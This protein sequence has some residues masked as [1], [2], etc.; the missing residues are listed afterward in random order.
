MFSERSFSNNQ[1]K[2]EKMMK[3]TGEFRKALET[4]NLNEAENFLNEVAS[5]PESFPQYDERWLDHRQRELFQS[6]YQAEDWQGAKRVVEVTADALSQQGRKDRLEELS[7]L[8]YE[9]I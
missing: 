2:L 9:E 4:G 7:G 5:N 8:N 6:F 3:N 1:E